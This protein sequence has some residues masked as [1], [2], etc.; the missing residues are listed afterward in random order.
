MEDLLRLPK[1][2]HLLP[3]VTRTKAFPLGGRWRRRR[4]KGWRRQDGTTCRIVSAKEAV[5]YCHP[6]PKPSCIL[7]RP[8]FATR[9]ASHSL[10]TSPQGERLRLLSRSATERIKSIYWP[11]SAACSPS[12]FGNRSTNRVPFP[13]SLWASIVPSNSLT[14]NWTRER[15]MPLPPDARSLALS[16]R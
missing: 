10:G 14:R 4:R 13:T 5:T 12:T 3:S 11:K 2:F 16:T 1:A 6:S 15:P 9:S 7:L 8:T